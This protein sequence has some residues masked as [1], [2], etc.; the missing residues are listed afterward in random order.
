MQGRLGRLIRIPILLLA[1]AAAPW[2]AA[3]PDPLEPAD[4]LFTGLLGYDFAARQTGDPAAY[5]VV[6]DVTL[7]DQWGAVRSTVAAR[8][9][10]DDTTAVRLDSAYTRNFQ[11]TPLRVTF[12]DA[13]VAGADWALPLRFGGV[14]IEPGA[15]AAPARKPTAP[16]AVGFGEVPA[17]ATSVDTLLEAVLPFAIAMRRDP[18]IVSSSDIAFGSGAMN[19]T[20][21][22]AP[23]WAQI[24]ATPGRAGLKSLRQG[25]T[26]SRFEVGMLR[27]D[28]GVG[29]FDY[30]AP[31]AAGTLRY[32]LTGDLTGE[33]H[34]EAT[35]DT[36]AAGLVLAWSMSHVDRL[37]LS[38][39][40]SN[41]QEGAGLLGRISLNHQ[42]RGWNAALGYQQATGGFMQPGFE[43]AGQRVTEEARAS[44]TIAL[45]ELGNLALAYSLRQGADDS[46]REV[47]S[48]ILDM[49][50]T[51]ETH[52]MAVGGISRTDGS[53]S[54]GL[55][56]SI[57]LGGL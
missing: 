5:G 36:Q 6:L 9:L 41:A 57:P 27:D 3:H 24:A 1:M 49:P 15:G 43:D 28:Y 35:P 54:I 7:S 42:G 2:R 37:I 50:F 16:D 10:A 47:A 34:A 22:N 21:R 56:F 18:T 40:A 48:F 14:A 25:E 8:G 53:A 23:P 17:L 4:A 13:V 52:I 32:G 46:R 29:S 31:I 38:G 45:G 12:G 39:A 19:F 51:D 55:S 11:D 30:G 26:R 33:T 44:G 20:V